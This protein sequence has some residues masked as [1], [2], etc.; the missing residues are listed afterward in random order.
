MSQS[1]VQILLPQTTVTSLTRGDKKPAAAYYLANADLQTVS[2]SVT[3]MTG[4]VTI[5]ASLATD[6]VL[7]N[8]NDWFNVFTFN[9]SAVVSLPNQPLPATQAGT[10][11][12]FHNLPGNF[13]WLRAVVTGSLGVVQYIKVS[14]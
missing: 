12:G 4:T 7:T 10:H 5:Q 9:A 6:P 14:Y 13:I 11:S 1:T 8:D 2:W 3:G